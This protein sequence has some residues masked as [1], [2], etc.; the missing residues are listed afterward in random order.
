MMTRHLIRCVSLAVV[1]GLLSAG[2]VNWK[3]R[4]QWPGEHEYQNQ[5][6]QKHHEYLTG[7]YDTKD[8]R[9]GQMPAKYCNYY[10]YMKGG[11]LVRHDRAAWW[12]DDGQLKAVCIYVH[13]KTMDRSMYYPNGVRAERVEVDDD[14][15]RAL[16]YDKAGKLFGRQEY[17]NQTRKRTYVLRDKI[18]S[19]NA[20]QFEYAEVVLGVKKIRP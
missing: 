18:V 9:Q 11:K 4:K 12:Y 2:C 6:V 7:D 14:G 1:C 3:D 13:G 19:E 10:A 17:D 5:V 20:F 8:V 16:F 15:E